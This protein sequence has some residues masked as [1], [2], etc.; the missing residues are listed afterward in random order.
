MVKELL[1]GDNPFIGV[2]HLAQEKARETQR[3]LSIER[4]VEVL[5]AAIDAGAVGFTFTVHPANL[6]LLNY[7]KRYQPNILNKLSFYI[8]VPYVAGYVREATRT[9]MPGLIKKLMKKMLA[10]SL[11]KDGLLSLMTPI[12]VNIVKLFLDSELK[13]YMKILP[14]NN[15]KAVLLHETLTELIVAFNI[16]EIVRALVKH[17]RRKNIGF[18]LE[19]RNVLRT[20]EF[21]M[22]NDLKVD[23]V[24]TPLNPLGYQMTPSKEDAE[25]A[26]VR[27]STWGIKVIAINILASGA[28]GS[29]DEVISYLKQF[30][31]YIYAVAVGTSKP[32]RAIAVFS[33]LR[34]LIT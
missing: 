2:S 30:R 20:M 8:L 22:E 31:D 4:K 3:E 12:P 25:R 14:R 34:N 9:G 21:L 23:Y 28:V 11:S 13:E 32:Q 10:T 29:M 15:V 5:N 7:I 17:F 18:G 24:M 27:L 16:P 6:E 26:I 33:L 19:T 1:L